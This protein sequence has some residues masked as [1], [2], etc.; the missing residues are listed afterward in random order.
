MEENK[1]FPIFLKLETLSVLLVG[2]GNVGLEKL[3]ALL[4]NSPATRVT[5]VATF[6]RDEFVELA[7]RAQDVTMVTRG[8]EM[9]DLDAADIVI[10]ATDN[11]ALHQAVREETRRRRILTNVADT[12]DLCDF[13]LG[14][15]FQRGN[16]K[17]GI[18]TNGKSPTFAKR[19]REFLEDIVPDNVQD[20]LQSL[21]EYRAT[22][23]DDFE[24]KVNALNELTASL[25]SK[26]K[27]QK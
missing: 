22:L 24:H 11:F 19:F 3:S 1:L 27:E 13:Y 12:P 4:K 21:H 9:T 16:L 6:F 5:A 18:S 8:F 7:E 2:G 26:E 23:K 17:I 10:L 20:L 14:S 15:V 25:V